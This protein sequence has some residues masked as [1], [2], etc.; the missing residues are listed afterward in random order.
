MSKALR[1]IL[2]L[3]VIL[4]LMTCA[5]TGGVVTGW[6]IPRNLA[7]N[8]PIPIPVPQEVTSQD[9]GTP[10]ELSE[11]F[12]PFWYAWQLVHQNYVDQPVNDTVLMQ[13]AIRGMMQSLGDPH[14]SYMDPD[15][16]RQANTPLE[17]EY[18]GIGAWV[19][20]SGEYL[21]IISP[22]PNSPA[23]K[24]GLKAEDQIV[25]VDGEDVTG[26]DGNLVLRRVLGPAGTQVTLTI[27]RPEMTE[28]FDV[29][30]TRAKI[31]IPSVESKMLEGNIAYI[32]IF[33]FGENTEK[34]LRQQLEDLM[35]QNPVGIILDLRN[36]GGGYLYTAVAVVSQF[37]SSGPVLYEVY[38]DGKRDTYKALGNGIATE[39]PL[40]VLVNEGTASASEITAGAIQDYQRGTLVGTTTFG[41]G[42]VQ[43]WQP[44]GTDDGAVR[45]TVARWLTPKERQ[46][47][48]IG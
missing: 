25:A 20:I 18:E 27:R 8:L 47:N 29:T 15:Q 35:A 36:N 42:S 37:I 19:D 11:L 44:L 41:K 23:E 3:V 31:V 7:R 12:Q 26:M 9:T 1:I 30:I 28:T 10:S 40:V 5:F 48:G 14:T 17:G 34:D 22:M 43:I 38:G 6:S 39:I 24:A 16:Y 32:Q 21:K 46:I 33:T 13:G 4:F 45:I 2:S